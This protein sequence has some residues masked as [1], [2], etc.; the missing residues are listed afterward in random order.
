MQTAGDMEYYAGT[1]GP[2]A[3]A[4]PANGTYAITWTS[5]VPSWSSLSIPTFPPGVVM[6]YGGASAPTSWLMCDGSAVSRS[7]YA[8][9]YSIIGTNYGT[10]NGTTTFNLPDMRGRFPFGKAASGTTGITL[11]GSFGA[12]DHTHTIPDHSHSS[13]VHSHTGTT[14]SDGDHSH[15]I[16]QAND[17]DRTG[18]GT[19]DVGNPTDVDGAHTHAFTT[20]NSAA[21]TTGI[22][23]LV[24]GTNNP[25][26]LVFNFIIKT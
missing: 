2:A 4:A 15:A 1:S 19:G 24:A 11:G 18:G 26:A 6:P 17:F 16:N 25:P 23:S 12:L 9:L 13:P 10:G 3:L 8:T 20:N 7:T 5:N 22:T 14:D 21:A